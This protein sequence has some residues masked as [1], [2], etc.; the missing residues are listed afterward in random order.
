MHLLSHYPGHLEYFNPRE[1]D[2]IIYIIMCHLWYIRTMVSF[3][4]QTLLRCISSEYKNYAVCDND[5]TLSRNV[6]K[7]GVAY[8]RT[9]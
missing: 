2:I 6:G 1:I 8:F 9:T 7:G 5:L 3:L 4:S